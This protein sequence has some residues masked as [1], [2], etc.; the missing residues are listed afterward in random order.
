MP[1]LIAVGTQLFLESHSS[2]RNHGLTRFLECIRNCS[3]FFCFFF[4]IDWLLNRIHLSLISFE[5]ILL[6]F[7]IY[8]DIYIYIIFQSRISMCFLFVFL[9]GC[10]WI[11]FSLIFLSY[12]YL[13]DLG[14][15]EFFSRAT[16]VLFPSC[17]TTAKETYAI[18]I[19]FWKYL[20]SMT[21]DWYITWHHTLEIG[22][23]P[24]DFAAFFLTRFIARIVRNNSMW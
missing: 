10:P 8:Y 24:T 9:V 20:I 18:S 11:S 5:M 2:N 17:I 4:W 13:S 12:F 6:W 14:L 22:T 21:D 7:L 16:I 23:G 15:F 3:F 1:L 19:F